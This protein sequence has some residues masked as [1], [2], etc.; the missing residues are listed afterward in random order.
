MALEE[1]P[2]LPLKPI[3][4]K[5]LTIQQMRE[6]LVYSEIEDTSNKH[7]RLGS[8]MNLSDDNGKLTT[9][10]QVTFNKSER[11]LGVLYNSDEEGRVL[12]LQF[13]VGNLL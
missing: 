11:L 10:N 6:A 4:P 12:N 3:T 9:L 1:N 2:A 13:V 8:P 7:F 5:S